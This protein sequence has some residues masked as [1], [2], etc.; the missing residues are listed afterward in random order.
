MKMTNLV[1]KVWTI[2]H[3][4]L[5]LPFDPSLALRDFPERQVPQNL[6]KVCLLVPPG[7]LQPLDPVV[8]SLLRTAVD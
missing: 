1:Q 5:N 8:S 6:Y 4:D 2:W 7:D 3:P